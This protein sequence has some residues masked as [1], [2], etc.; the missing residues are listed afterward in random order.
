MSHTDENTLGWRGIE[1]RS[2]RTENHL[3]AERLSALRD[4]GVERAE[5]LPRAGVL[6][7]ATDAVLLCGGLHC[8]RFLAEVWCVNFVTLNIHTMPQQPAK[9]RHKGR[10]TQTEFG[11]DRLSEDHLVTA[12]DLEVL[13]RRVRL[14]VPI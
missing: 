13:V 6:E 12:H 4:N 3:G 8:D 2:R 5:A 7:L 9:S 14:C 11:T 1:S 10:S